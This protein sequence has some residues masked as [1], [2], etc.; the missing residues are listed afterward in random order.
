VEGAA[1]LKP[2]EAAEVK[3]KGKLTMH[4]VTRDETATAK[5][6]STDKGVKV[7]ATFKVSLP[8]YKVAVP[9]LVR[10]KVNDEIQLNVS[11][12]VKPK[13]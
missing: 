10:L 12:L 2:G 9:S 8:N 7:Q 11:L 4:G 5:V 13:K 1:A 6:R 3:V